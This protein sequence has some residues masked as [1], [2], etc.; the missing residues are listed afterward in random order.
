MSTTTIS[1][2]LTDNNNKQ[3]ETTFKLFKQLVETKIDE[4]NNIKKFPEF[5]NL[6]VKELIGS[7]IDN[8]MKSIMWIYDKFGDGN[9]NLLTF[10]TKHLIISELLK[11]K[12]KKKAIIIMQKLLMDNNYIPESTIIH[13]MFDNF[14]SYDCKNNLNMINMIRNFFNIIKKKDVRQLEYL[15]IYTRMIELECSSFNI[16]NAVIYFNEMKE[17]M[18]IKL[19]DISYLSLINGFAKMGMMDKAEEYFNLMIQEG[20]SP[21]IEIFT[22]LINNYLRLL[23]IEKCEQLFQIMKSYN[24]KPNITTYNVIIHNSVI[25][26]DME[27]AIKF[28]NEIIESGIKPDIVTFS[29]LLKGYLNVGDTF[30]ALEINKMLHDFKDFGIEPNRAYNILLMKVYIQNK[31]LVNAEKVFLSIINSN[32]KSLT[33]YLKILLQKT[34]D[35]NSTY[36]LYKRFLEKFDNYK[37]EFPPDNYFFTLFISS[38]AQKHHDMNLAIELFEEMKKREIKPSIVTYSILIDGFALKGQVDKAVEYF[39]ILKKDSIEP[40]VFA[41]TSLIKAWVQVNNKDNA[42]KVYDEMINKNIQPVS[43]TLRALQNLTRFPNTKRRNLIERATNSQKEALYWASKLWISKDKETVDRLFQSFISSI[44]NSFPYQDV[45]EE[46]DVKTFR[47][48]VTCYLFKYRD[49]ASALEVFR[50]MLKLNIK[51]DYKLYSDFIKGCCML[52]Q[53]EKLEKIKKFKENKRIEKL[54]NLTKLK[55]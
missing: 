42:K 5:T 41:Y 47:Y 18:G 23:N 40:N 6:L 52:G 31:D 1:S 46:P 10:E 4:L 12:Q 28:F 27:T 43:A 49:L 30:K 38:F 16:D 15:K 20:I 37:Y 35:K 25:N 17:T 26:L 48:F 50:E 22:T 55:I 24:I 36:E 53:V 33:L 29:T 3:I 8:E 13:E 7:G 34:K 51:P 45:D 14:K 19:D 44:L 39:E 11:Y 2:D 21:S 54:L 32:I 9:N